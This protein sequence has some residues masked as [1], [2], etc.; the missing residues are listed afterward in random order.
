MVERRTNSR[1]NKKGSLVD[2]IFSAAYILK[3]AVTVLICLFVWVSFQVGMEDVIAGEPS[4]SVLQPVLDSLRVSYF[5]ID[6]VFPILV[7]GLMIISLIFAFK[8]GAN[9]IWGILSL[10][11]WG[12]ALLMSA[13]FVN[14]YISVSNEFPAIYAEMPI[15]D[16]IMSNLNWIILFWLAIICLVMFRK[17]NAED[18]ITGAQGRFYK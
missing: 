3:V 10:V 18:E 16:I 17:N 1:M 12:L 5:S 15:M 14:V 13:V 8:T 11:V 6:Y 2:P 7:G 9:F 4:E